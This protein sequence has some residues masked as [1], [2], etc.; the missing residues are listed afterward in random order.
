MAQ[1]LSRPYRGHLAVNVEYLME[2][3]FFFPFSQQAE[4]NE[5]PIRLWYRYLPDYFDEVVKEMFQI[6]LTGA[7]D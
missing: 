7:L 4:I 6:P 1:R 5:L 3:L 2:Y